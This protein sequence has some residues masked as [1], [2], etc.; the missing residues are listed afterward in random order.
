MI[1]VHRWG[2]KARRSRFGRSS[3]LPGSVLAVVAC[4]ALLVGG[5]SNR[6]E[7]EPGAAAK[8]TVSVDSQLHD[9]LP[10][11]IVKRGEL[12]VVTDAS[13]PPIE[14]F[15]DDG[16]TIVGVDPDIAQALAAV[17]GVKVTLHNVDFGALIDRVAAGK[18]D[19]AMS[20]M[21]DTRARE[22][23]LDFVNYF[24][25]GTSIVVQRGNP[26]S[27]TDLG[28]LC[29]RTVAVEK[30]TTQESLIGR[31]Q[32]RCGNAITVLTGTSNDDAL[33]LL[34]TGRAVAVLMDYPPAEW[35]TTDPKTHAHYE[36][37]TT[38]QYEPG[39]YGIGFAKGNAT[40]RDVVRDALG[41][42][43]ANGTYQAILDRWNVGHGA[44]TGVS[45]NAATVAA[46]G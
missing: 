23:R 22:A 31:Y 20:A 7:A 9:R 12:Q 17:L 28:S 25:A 5:C 19:M 37:S 44:V 42:L 46:G 8:A 16:Q 18:A 13:Y 10:A 26:E 30:D 43:I 15:A 41:Q 21:T 45:I 34:R 38:A 36:M 39:L 2:Q 40:L 3:G 11:D 4:L 27:V 32:S 33:L 6:V 14:S 24:A 1:T 29:G 35:L